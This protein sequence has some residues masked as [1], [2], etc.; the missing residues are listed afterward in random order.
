MKKFN[1]RIKTALRV[2][3]VPNYKLAELLGISEITLYRN[4]LR[5]EE[6]LPTEE[7]D[8]VIAVIE[9]YAKEREER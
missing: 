5:K 2:N 4:Y 7:I 1:S 6:T 9:Q 8:K 3:D